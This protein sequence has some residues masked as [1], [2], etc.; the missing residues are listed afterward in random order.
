[1]KHTTNQ[2]L[3]CT[4][5]VIIYSAK[6]FRGRVGDVGAGMAKYK[7]IIFQN[8]SDYVAFDIAPG[9]ILMW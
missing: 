3:N 4:R 2:N 9:K 7:S 1:M 8:A 5:D 6:Y